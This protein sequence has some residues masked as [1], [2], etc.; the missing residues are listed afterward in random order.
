MAYGSAS[1]PQV[2]GGVRNT[3]SAFA[4]ITESA[5]EEGG[6]GGFRGSSEDFGK[7]VHVFRVGLDKEN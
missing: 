7:L 6:G 1:A 3:G 4:S 5:T 2:A